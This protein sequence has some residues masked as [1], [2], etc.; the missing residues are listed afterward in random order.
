VPQVSVLP[1][2]RNLASVVGLHYLAKDAATAQQCDP[3]RVAGGTEPASMRVRGHR[4]AA[5]ILATAPVVKNLNTSD[6][7]G[8]ILNRRHTSGSNHAAPQYPCRPWPVSGGG[9]PARLPGVPSADGLDEMLAN[10]LVT[11]SERRRVRL[12]LERGSALDADEQAA[13]M[14]LSMYRRVRCPKLITR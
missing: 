10:L 9:H 5:M 4:S 14:L 1:R 8:W 7:Q 12:Q 13:V 6:G 3:V 2:P 11:A